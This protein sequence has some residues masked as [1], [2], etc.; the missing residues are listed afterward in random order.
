[1]KSK[2]SKTGINLLSLLL[3]FCISLLFINT[4]FPWLA[5]N[6][7]TGLTDR[8]YFN[9]EMMENSENEIIKDYAGKISLINYLLWSIIIISLLSLLGLTYH[10]F[11][12]LPKIF[13]YLMT[14]FGIALFAIIILIMNLYYNIFTYFSKNSAISHATLISHLNFSHF[15]IIFLFFI[16]IITIFYAKMQIKQLFLKRKKFKSNVMNKKQIQKFQTEKQTIEP[17]REKFNNKRSEVEEWLVDEIKNIDEKT[18][19]SNKEQF[20]DKNKQKNISFQDKSFEEND[21]LKNL[22]QEQYRNNDFEKKSIPEP[23]PK[24]KPKEKQT[25]YNLKI[26]DSFEK[27]LA[28]AI[29]KKQSQLKQIQ[30]IDEKKEIK[31]LDKILL[32]KDEIK[33]DTKKNQLMVRCPQCTHLF[34]AERKYKNT[35]IMCPQCGKEGVIR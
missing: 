25:S 18:Q 3:F 32:K 15:S 23:F 17:D 21:L 20:W 31:K 11:S 1:M 2:T 27:A 33:Q 34:T 24:E 10:S 9:L 5:V 14:I 12:N 35:K 29:E 28:S 6:Q 7:N 8:Q 26:S 30:P 13:Q 4:L 22:E 16:L 19:Q